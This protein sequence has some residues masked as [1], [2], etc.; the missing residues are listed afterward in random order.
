LISATAVLTPFGIGEDCVLDALSAGRTAI[1]PCPRLAGSVPVP[2]PLAAFVPLPPPGR[3]RIHDLL[4]PI[5]PVIRDWRPDELVLATTKGEIDLLEQAL[6]AKLPCPECTLNALLEKML[7]ELSIP[8]GM[9]VSAACAS[10]TLALMHGAEHLLAGRARRVAVVGIDM[11]SRFVH[12]GFAALQALSPTVARPFSLHRDGLS[13]GEGCGAVLLE[14]VGPGHLPAAAPGLLLGWGAAA[15]ANHVTGPS[16][17]GAG[18]AAAIRAALATAA[19]PAEAVGG[20]CAHGTGTVYN[21]RMEML[22]FHSVFGADAPRPACSMKGAI[23]HAMG[24]AGIVETIVSLRALRR[25]VLP[26]TV[27]LGEPAPEAVGWVSPQTQ[28]LSAPCLL[29][30]SSGFGGINA[31]LLLATEAIHR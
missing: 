16:R 31:A 18:L 2:P 15:D 6:A 1:H 21:D 26:G 23:G 24:A 8:R 29:K 14:R 7:R 13:L 22:A 30:T 19:I 27:G 9:V 3:S 25:S 17:D 20:I 4:W 28:A 12:S 11:V 5:A 10:S